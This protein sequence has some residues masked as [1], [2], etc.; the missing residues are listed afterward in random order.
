MTSRD[1]ADK[2]SNERAVTPAR[3]SVDRFLLEVSGRAKVVSP[4]STH[5]LLF[6]IDATASRQPTWD[7]ACELHDELFTEAARLGNIA[8]QLCYFR[9]LNEF[10]ASQWATT[11]AQLRDQM[12]AV[13]CRAG[14][15]QLVRLL[16]HALHQA[17]LHPVRALVF[18]G[19]CCEEDHAELVALAG[20]LALRAL[21]V[22]IFQEH[23]DPR[24]EQTF[25][26][27]ARITRG[28]HVAFDVNSPDELRRL[29]GAVAQYAMGGREA[30]EEFARRRGTSKTRSLLTQLGPR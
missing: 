26:A 7:L 17:A 11:P 1:G 14:R 12:N 10:S 28:A 18:I 15:T 29:L 5:R 13:V 24:A 30:L 20:Q 21:P 9:G 27:I 23:S 4:R 8:I 2:P 19:D 25:E 22:F 6:A 3:T 16:Q